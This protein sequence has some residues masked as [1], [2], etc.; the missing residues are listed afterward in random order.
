MLTDDNVEDYISGMDYGTSY[1]NDG[2]ALYYL[3][4][5]YWQSARPVGKNLCHTD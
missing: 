3:T 5:R 4:D 2:T 1:P